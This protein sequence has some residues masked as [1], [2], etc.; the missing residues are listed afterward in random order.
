MVHRYNPWC[1]EHVRTAEE[2]P[3]PRIPDL[4]AVCAVRISGE[5]W[6]H[7]EGYMFWAEFCGQNM[8]IG[9]RV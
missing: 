9:G 3:L 4:T 2:T 6:E 5:R 1:D 7:G 8:S